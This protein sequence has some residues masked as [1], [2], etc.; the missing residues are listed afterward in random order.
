MLSPSN[1]VFFFFSIIS[2]M[3]TPGKYFLSGF[4]FLC[5]SF[6][7]YGQTAGQ[8]V[9]VTYTSSP[10][11]QYNLSQKDMQ[12]T[13]V[14][15]SLYEFMKGITDY[16]SLYINLKD[17]SSVYILD[18]TVQVRPRGWED[19]QIRAAL[20][21]TVIF[22]LKSAKNKTY[23]HE[24]I[25]NQTFFTE[26]EVGDISWELGSEKKTIDGL[27]CYR[28]VAKDKYPMLTVW[29]TRD[30]PISNGPSIYQGLPGLVVWVEDY[31]R[32]TQIRNI[33]YKDDTE[34]FDTLYRS[35][36]DEFV[37]EKERKKRY[38]KEPILVIKKADLANF[39][40]AH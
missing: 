7:G 27:T 32:T 20:T 28:A 18:S 38:D 26:G 25:M 5:L 3:I 4:A 31:F 37:R 8:I 17:R 40:A 15:A 30:L 2:M 29:Y 39:L 36:Y 13:A 10:V 22:A 6:T 21:D 24:W 12:G 35:K 23:K 9:K 34:A 11:S 14:K 33:T 16:Y 1:A 19:S